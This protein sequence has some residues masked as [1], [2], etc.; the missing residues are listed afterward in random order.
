M[1]SNE[2]IR[3]F[4]ADELDTTIDRAQLTD[5]VRL[6]DEKIIDSI[7]IFEMIDFLETHFDIEIL[8]EELLPENFATI[9][10]MARLVDSKGT[11]G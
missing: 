1:T 10:T 2:V 9:G 11:G 3:G 4:I 7:A 5:D 8:D 6:I